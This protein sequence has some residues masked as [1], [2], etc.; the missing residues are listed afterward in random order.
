MLT[1]SKQVLAAVAT[2]LTPTERMRVDAAGEGS[3]RAL[4]RDSVED[5]IHDLKANR[6]QAVLVSVNRCDQ[7]ARNTVSLM[8]REFPRIPT[9]ALLTQLE[10][11][12]PHAMLLLGQSGVRQVIDVREPKG[13]RELRSVLVTAHGDQVQRRMLAQLGIDLQGVSDDCWCFFET[14]FKVLPRISTV[15]ALCQQLGVLPS[16]LMS[17]F[18]RA[19][20]PAPK[21]Y[22]AMA[23]LV[24]AARLFENPGF[25]IANVANHLDYSSPQSF[26]RH[27]RTMMRITAV[28]FRTRFDGEGMLEEFRGT[29]VTPYLERLRKFRPLTPSLVPFWRQMP[30]H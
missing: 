21:R 26:G 7:R 19:G 3:Y 25:S 10:Q 18:F 17:R 4:H 27:V 9:V 2:I 30:P 1:E 14:L 8:V 24:R 22:L 28:E 13:W 16:T 20:V 29:L 15:R 11:A 5:V 6:A 23:R 12:T